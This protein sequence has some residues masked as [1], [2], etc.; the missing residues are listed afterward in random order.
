[1]ESTPDRGSINLCDPKQVRALLE[2]GGVRLK[3]TLGQNFL[4]NAAIPKKIAAEL[5][6]DGS[7]GVLEVG[8]G[9]GSLTSELA[10]RAARVVSVE[11]DRTLLPVLR[12]LFSHDEGVGFVEADILK[13]DIPALVASELGDCPH[14]A[15]ISNL[16]YYITSPA[17]AAL[18]D[19]KCFE[20][21]I[22]MVQKEVARR[23]C[24]APGSA[25]Y[26]AFTAYVNYHAEPSVLFSV[27]AGS[28]LPPPK[29]DSAVIRLDMRE[30]P[31]VAVTNETLFFEAIKAGF[32][33][34]RKTLLNCLAGLC[35]GREEAARA[36]AGASI[37]PM[38]R[39]ETLSL[40]EFAALSEQIGMLRAGGA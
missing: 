32:A 13:I 14:K 2:Q 30:R 1:M 10:D 31:A 17:L 26:S 20:T 9:A 5:P 29:V 11:L 22:V 34:R 38:R 18:I 36:L 16:P 23:I 19:A 27:S 6:D 4:I 7:W 25:D 8:P 39:G 21:I 33:N 40:S 3:K 37:D 35:G 12:S 28:F 15:A 24:S